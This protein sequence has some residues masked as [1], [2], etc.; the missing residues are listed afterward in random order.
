MVFPAST[1]RA[2][3][4]GRVGNSELGETT[5]MGEYVSGS[6]F[7]ADTS[8][9]V[10][11]DPENEDDSLYWGRVT[12]Q[13]AGDNW[14]RQGG[15]LNVKKDSFNVYQAINDVVAAEHGSLSLRPR[16]QGLL[17]EP[18]PPAERS[19]GSQSGFRR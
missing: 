3:V 14:V 2:W 15:L 18:S 13:M 8:G 1:A 10:W 19:S 5:E 7:L 9:L 11:P 16:G 6:T 17:L 4:L 12:L